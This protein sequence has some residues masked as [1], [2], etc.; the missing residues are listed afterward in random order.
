MLCATRNAYRVLHEASAWR[1]RQDARHVAAADAPTTLASARVAAKCKG[2]NAWQA[3]TMG[4]GGL[5]RRRRRLLSRHIDHAQRRACSRH[6]LDAYMELAARE[7]PTP[8]LARLHGRR[9]GVLGRRCGLVLER[10]TGHSGRR[11]GPCWTG[12]SRD[13]SSAAWPLPGRCAGVPSARLSGPAAVQAG[14][15]AAAGKAGPDAPGYRGSYAPA[16][17]PRTSASAARAAAPWAPAAAASDTPI[18]VQPG[19]P[20]ASMTLLTTVKDDDA[21]DR[22]Q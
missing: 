12:T 14:V 18:V 2:K 11:S 21:L 17:A 22:S 9:G 5:S 10:P 13:C 19:G 1:V 16:A 8:P 3:S 20:A 4:N 6:W 15:A 7:S